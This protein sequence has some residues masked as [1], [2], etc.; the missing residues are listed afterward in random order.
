MPSLEK[1][2]RSG[3]SFDEMV[4]VAKSNVDLYGSVRARANPPTEYAARIERTGRQWHFLVLSEDWCGDA[5]NIVPWVDAL[6]I[7]SS[8][9][10]MRIIA[11][12]E[13][14]DLMDQHLT[15]G[16]SRSIPVVLLLDESYVERAWW[17]PRPQAL[18]EWATGAEAQAMEKDAR[19]RELRRWYARDRGQSILEE[20]TGMVER[21]AAQ[22]RGDVATLKAAV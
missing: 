19:Y 12:D 20:I 9:L 11:R 6:A 5:V 3:L 8:N 10:D 22:D 7:S 17:G 21:V 18:Q 4:A 15:N 14:L 16:K 2:F 1:R 13:N